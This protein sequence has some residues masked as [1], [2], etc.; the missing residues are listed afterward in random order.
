ME[1]DTLYW[2]L[3]T[4][5][6]VIGALAGLQIAGIT[7]FYQSLDKRVERDE[8]AVTAIQEMKRR[9]YAETIT[10]LVVSIAA[11]L[12]DVILLGL[13]PWLSA[14]LSGFG[15]LVCRCRVLLVT[16]CTVAAMLNV[17][18]FI[19]L[20]TLLKQILDPSYQ[21][22]VN[23]LLADSEKKGVA[24]GDSVTSQEF[25][26]HFIRFEKA[27]RDFFPYTMRKSPLRNLI[28]LLVRENIIPA[29][30]VGDIQSVINKRNIM[31]HGN[32][33]GRVG[34]NVMDF[35]AKLTAVLEKEREPY[36]KRTRA[37]R[38][39]N[40]FRMWIDNN[41][42]DLQDA[43]CLDHAV[44]YKEDYGMY[45]V[46]QDGEKLFVHTDDSGSLYLNGEK[47]VKLFLDI[48]EEKHGIGGLSVEDSA[49]FQRAIDKDD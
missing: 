13:T 45:K 27:V 15:S 29:G 2:I 47:A 40:H 4:L 18:V 33:I 38:M 25:L 5:P 14:W 32:D 34:N 28:N 23:A 41:V 10:I 21:Q 37:S 30:D 7:F 48:L 36:M 12:A 43:E 11:I 39:D 44:R 26:E 31:V 35:L 42:D 17:S 6:Q 16:V 19:K 9:I 1:E 24:V 46:S 22:E 49:S 3:S 20:Y 8:S